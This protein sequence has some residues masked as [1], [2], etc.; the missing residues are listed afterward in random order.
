MTIIERIRRRFRPAPPK[1][2]GC[3]QVREG[4][5]HDFVVTAPPGYGYVHSPCTGSISWGF[6]TPYGEGAE[7]SRQMRGRTSRTR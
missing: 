1:Q 4:I 2:C 6:A 3:G 5:P 7:A